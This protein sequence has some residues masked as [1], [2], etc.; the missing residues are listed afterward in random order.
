MRSEGLPILLNRYATAV[1]EYLKKQLVLDG[2][3]VE[4]VVLKNNGVV[5]RP[6][7]R[8]LSSLERPVG[9]EVHSLEDRDA[10]VSRA[11]RRG[12]MHC[13]RR[14]RSSRQA[15]VIYTSST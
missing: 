6:V 13:V 14:P 3:E 15:R 10:T 1:I 5:L 12:D 9:H 4:Q 7:N 8:R 2:A 11:L